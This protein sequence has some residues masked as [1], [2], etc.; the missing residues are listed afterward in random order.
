MTLVGR[1]T[2]PG[3]AGRDH[4]QTIQLGYR[5]CAALTRRHGTTYFWGAALLPPQQRRD[6]YAV[7]ALCRL[8]D[9]IVDEPADVDLSGIPGVADLDHPAERLAGFA[10]AFRHGLDRGKVDDPVLAAV[11]DTVRRREID[12]ECFDR[13]F[14]AMAMDLSVTSWPSWAA[15]RDGY[16]EG[17]AAVIGE[18]MLPVLEPYTPDARMPARALGQA[19]QLTNFIRDVAEDLDRGRVY[20][21]ADDLARHGADPSLRQVSPQWRSFLAEQIERNRGLYREAEPGLAMLPPASARCV[22]TALVLY[23]QIL[24]RIEQADYDVF[25]GRV[26]VPTWRKAVT[27]ADSIARRSRTSGREGTSSAR[28][29]ML[30]VHRLSQ[31]AQTATSPTWRLARPDRI[32][33]ALDVALERNPGGWYVVGRSADVKDSSI[34]RSIAGHEVVLWRTADGT[35]VAGPGAC[36]HL[37]AKLSDCLVADS[38]LY[39]RWHGLALTPQG[40]DGW[41]PWPALDDGVLLWVRLPTPG[42]PP[43]DAPAVSARPDP[44]ASISAV[45]TVAGACEPRDVVANRLDPWHGSWFH[46]YAFSHLRVDDG[47]STDACLVVDVTFR[48]TRGLG[49]PVRAEFSCPDARS[50]VMRIVEGEGVGSVVETHAT[51]LGL[52]RPGRPRTGPPRTMMTEATIAFSPR[53]G[54]RLARGVSPLIRQA[55]RHSARQLWVDDMAYAERRYELRSR[56]EFGQP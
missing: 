4:D 48:L 51:P 37:G 49:V 41:A 50:I 33:Q 9:D 20:L 21:P 27:A 18:M 24:D 22:G 56:G 38:V 12:P 15:L 52:D 42:E 54:F 5:R 53:S 8:A 10:A 1:D 29:A 28:T 43:T 55:M 45:V 40:N 23:E 26:R 31:P 6:V 2:P 47:A 11:V 46:P 7:Y 16:M 13:F 34:V 32:R 30:P 35:L 25:T 39:C 14:Q 36:P 19:F 17:S 3:N 44:S